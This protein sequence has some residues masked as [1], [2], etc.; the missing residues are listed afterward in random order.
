MLFLM[1]RRTFVKHSSVFA[2]AVALTGTS[3]LAIEP[4]KNKLPKWKDFN[5]LDF[6]SPNPSDTPG[7]T[8]DEHLKWIE[9]WHGYKL[10][11]QLLQLMQK[12]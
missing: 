9:D 6:F 8:T 3:A 1:N 4:T 10:D 2:T 11:R 5:L 12:A 7:G